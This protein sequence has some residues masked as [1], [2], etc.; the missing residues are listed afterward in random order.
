MKFKT[1]DIF[2]VFVIL[3]LVAAVATASRWE[4]RA[5]IMIL[6]LGGFGI[7]AA[8]TQLLFDVFK[9]NASTAVRAKPTMELPTFEDAD[10]RATLIGTFE[11]WAWMI[12]VVVATRIFG[13]PLTLP[14][15]VVVY[16]RFYG[17]SWKMALFLAALIAAFIFG[18]YQQI[19]H[20]YWPE[21]LLGDLLG[22]D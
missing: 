1:A 19:M 6:V 10:P 17:A 3:I 7:V 13:L 20:V 12:G 8:T 5:S 14:L 22:W 21:S 4:L 9:A 2:T 16:A 18:V 15:F 11:I